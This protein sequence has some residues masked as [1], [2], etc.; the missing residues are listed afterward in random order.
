MFKEFVFTP[1]ENFATL[2]KAPRKFK[3]VWEVEAVFQK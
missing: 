3:K 1:V 2:E